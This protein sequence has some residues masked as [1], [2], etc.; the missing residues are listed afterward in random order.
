MDG[1]RGRNSL[2]WTRVREGHASP[3]LRNFFHTVPGPCSNNP[4]FL[5]SSPTPKVPPSPQF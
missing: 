1:A 5:D 4:R 2:Q 3:I